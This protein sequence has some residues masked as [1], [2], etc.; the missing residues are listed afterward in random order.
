MTKFGKVI[1]VIGQCVSNGSVRPH[2]KGW[3]SSVTKFLGIPAYSQTVGLRAATFGTITY[4][5]ERFLGG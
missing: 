5:G 4:V 3:G 2:P 1:Q